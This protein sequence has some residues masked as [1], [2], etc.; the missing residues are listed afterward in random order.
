MEGETYALRVHDL[1]GLE[2]FAFSEVR[3][4]EDVRLRR[5]QDKHKSECKAIEIQM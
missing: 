1:H 4:S 2:G 3:I 5:K